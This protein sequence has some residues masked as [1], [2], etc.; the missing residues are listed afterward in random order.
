[1]SAFSIFKTIYD[2]RNILGGIYKLAKKYPQITALTVLATL[3][4]IIIAYIIS[5]DNSA[6][7]QAT[8]AK[9]V[10][11]IILDAMEYKCKGNIGIVIGSISIED[12]VTKDGRAYPGVF[13]YAYVSENG[14]FVNKLEEKK[15]NNAYLP[16]IYVLVEYS[17]L[18]IEQ[19]KKS[20]PAYFNPKDPSSMPNFIEKL[21]LSISTWHQEKKMTALYMHT[22]VRRNNLIYVIALSTT[23]EVMS[24]SFD[25]ITNIF[26]DLKHAL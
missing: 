12:I 6:F 17:N 7:D 8:K 26:N 25:T 13:Q 21:L 10:R 11:G 24:C 3:P 14:N 18:L 20:Q 16:G 2:S 15:E 4:L 22:I 19:A 9:M 23:D 5:H 1:M